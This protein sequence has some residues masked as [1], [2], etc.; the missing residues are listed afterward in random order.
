MAFRNV[1]VINGE[2]IELKNLPPEEK[3]RLAELWNRRA[4]NSVGYEEEKTA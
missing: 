2:K 4:A 1:V 3:E